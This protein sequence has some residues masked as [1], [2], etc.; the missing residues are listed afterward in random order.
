MS[1]IKVRL[2]EYRWLDVQLGSHVHVSVIVD[3]CFVGGQAL[4]TR[5]F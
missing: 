3:I 1:C 2:E 5:T 4:C